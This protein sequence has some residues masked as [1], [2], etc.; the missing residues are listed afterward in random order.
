MDD[1]PILFISEKG[2]LL[3]LDPSNRNDEPEVVEALSDKI[4]VDFV[5]QFDTE[6]VAVLTDEGAVYLWW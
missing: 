6:K 1:A 2:E 3:K 5:R 4:I